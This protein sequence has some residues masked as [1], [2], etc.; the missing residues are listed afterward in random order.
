MIEVVSSDRCTRCNICVAVCPMDVF[1]PVPAGA[2]VIARQ[3]DCQTC[4][5]C[6]AH[7]PDDALYVAPMRAPVAADSP[8]RDEATLVRTGVI[9]SY[10]AR[11]GLGSDRRPP[12]TADEAFELAQ[13]GPRRPFGP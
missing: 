9:G 6:E 11:L 8:H 2:P 3:Q 1:D 4:F 5:M 7:C 10:R 12:R 13:I